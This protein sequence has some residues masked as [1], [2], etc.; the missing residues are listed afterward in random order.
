M[1]KNNLLYPP[2]P[3]LKNK[4]VLTFVDRKSNSTHVHFSFDK[5][6]PN[7]LTKNPPQ[8]SDVSEESDF[9]QNCLKF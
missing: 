2:S 5:D 6:L 8:S 7:T 1:P 3:A 9:G 4:T